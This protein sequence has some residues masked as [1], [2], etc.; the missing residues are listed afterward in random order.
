MRGRRQGDRAPEDVLLKGILDF[1]A[2]GRRRR[3]RDRLTRGTRHA[4]L[5]FRRMTEDSRESLFNYCQHE[6]FLGPREGC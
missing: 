4:F 5:R 1:K 6:G 2:S 3:A